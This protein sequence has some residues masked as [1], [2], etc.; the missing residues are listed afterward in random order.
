MMATEDETNKDD[1][2]LGETILGLDLF[3]PLGR[4]V[5]FSDTEHVK[6]I[7]AWLLELQDHRNQDRLI[8]DRNKH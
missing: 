2:D 8:R 3:I 4:G 5:Q 7:K 6:Q 1:V